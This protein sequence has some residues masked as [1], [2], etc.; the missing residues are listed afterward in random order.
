MDRPAYLD[1]YVF[2]WELFDVIIGG[3]SA[4]DAHSYLGPLSSID[5]VHDFLLSYGFDQSDPISQAEI[6]GI[7]QEAVQFIRRYF[8]KDGNSD[9]LDLEI[10]VSF[11]KI[12]NVTDLFIVATGNAPD[13]SIEECIWAGIIL[14]VMHT[15]LHADKDLRNHYFSIIQQQIFDRFYK[16]INRENDQLY[17]GKPGDPMGVK[18]LDFETKSKKSRDSVIIKLLHKRENVAEELFDR[19]GVRFVTEG[20]LDCLR[21]IKFLHLNNVIIAHNVKPSRS[22]NTLIDFSKFKTTY[23]NLIKMSIKNGLA[24][25]RFVQAVERELADLLPPLH[26]D[27][28]TNLH[29]SENYRSLQFT[30]RQM[31]R[32]QNPFVK[33]FTQ[34]RQFAKER[35]DDELAKKILSLDISKLN[36]EVRFFYPFEIQIADEQTHKINTEGEASHQDYKRSQLKSATKRLFGNLLDLRNIEIKTS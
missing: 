36:R 15:I 12:S 25:D 34:V 24:E 3:K 18:L 29:T 17:L 16:F 33:E 5:E 14:K 11:N 35:K 7:F 1:H 26:K 4:L 9:G 13:K 6:F 28:N 19:I 20:R 21:V 10:P 31:I 32:Y 22:Q 2:D 23:K 27:D 30:C 8:L